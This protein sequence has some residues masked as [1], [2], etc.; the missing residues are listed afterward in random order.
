MP[1]IAAP[2][3]LIVRKLGGTKSDCKETPGEIVKSF[4]TSAETY[5]AKVYTGYLKHAPGLDTDEYGLY[6]QI[7]HNGGGR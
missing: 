5:A 1:W 6:K 4:R 2:S 3:Y 7:V